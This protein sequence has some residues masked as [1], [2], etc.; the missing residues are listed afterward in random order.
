MPRKDRKKKKPSDKEVCKGRARLFHLDK[1]EKFGCIELT[2]RTK[3]ADL[4]DDKVF[5][6]ENISYCNKKCEGIVC[7]YRD[8]SKDNYKWKFGV[9]L[10]NER[11]GIQIA[12]FY[13]IKPF[14][15]PDV[16]VHNT[17]LKCV[18]TYPWKD[19]NDMIH[20]CLLN[21]LNGCTNLLGNYKK[22]NIVS[23]FDNCIKCSPN[24]ADQLKRNLMESDRVYINL[25]LQKQGSLTV[26]GNSGIL[27]VKVKLKGKTCVTFVDNKTQQTVCVKVKVDGEEVA[28]PEYQQLV[29]DEKHKEL[30]SY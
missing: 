13:S 21:Q 4:S 16:H 22:G 5:F 10:S 18:E 23:S 11:S 1:D 20:V 12:S 14:F 2:S 7:A 3:I 25:Q 15:K 8:N 24:G 30:V 9:I 27:D 17:L 19:A 6:L 28:M 26:Q 29:E